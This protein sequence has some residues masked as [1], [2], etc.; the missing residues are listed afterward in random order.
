LAKKRGHREQ[1]LGRELWDGGRL[2]EIREKRGHSQ[3]AL[4]LMTG[5]SKG[6]ISRHE[7]NDVASNPSV[8]GLLRIALALHVPIA[9]LFEPVGTV[10]PR[11]GEVPGDAERPRDY[12]SSLERLRIE[13]LDAEAPAEDSTRGDILRAQ[14]ALEAAH[15]ALNRALRRADKESD[16]G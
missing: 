16:T 3:D 2:R 8:A 4:A 9:A 15:A 12:V 14:H 10:I 1:T 13:Q 5:V 6:D 11:P 7:R